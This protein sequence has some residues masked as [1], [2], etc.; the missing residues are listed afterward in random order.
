M[1]GEIK[2]F[3]SLLNTAIRRHKEISAHSYSYI[4]SNLPTRQKLAVGFRSQLFGQP[5]KKSKRRLRSWVGPRASLDFGENKKILVPILSQN[6][7]L[8]ARSLITILD[9]LSR[10]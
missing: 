10:L 1:K 9:K 5:L 8:E 2:L 7:D 6:Q 4:N 3:E